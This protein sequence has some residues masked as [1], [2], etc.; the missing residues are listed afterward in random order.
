MVGGS[1]GGASIVVSHIVDVNLG[2]LSDNEYEATQAARKL[3]GDMRA[4]ARQGGYEDEYVHWSGSWVGDE[5]FKFNRPAWMHKPD[6]VPNGVDSATFRH[7]TLRQYY[8]HESGGGNKLPIKWFKKALSGELG[9]KHR[10]AANLIQSVSSEVYRRKYGESGLLYRTGEMQATFSASESKPLASRTGKFY[11]SEAD[12]HTV[13]IRPSDV[14]FSY[15]VIPS[16]Y[17]EREWV[18][19]VKE[20]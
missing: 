9:I 1:G 10:H 18:V 3:I 15:R 19:G 7:T 20:Q 17:P 11:G 12:V 14:L 6:Y 2:V 5:M 13:K 8:T 4:I 16:P